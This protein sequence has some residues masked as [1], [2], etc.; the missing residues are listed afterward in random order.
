[1]IIA[2]E[3]QGNTKNGQEL[4]LFLSS[5]ITPMV[6]SLLKHGIDTG[7]DL[8]LDPNFYFSNQDVDTVQLY[9]VRGTKGDQ[10]L[11][12]YAFEARVQMKGDTHLSMVRYP[13]KL[14]HFNYAGEFYKLSSLSMQPFSCVTI[15]DLTN[16]LRAT[17]VYGY[18]LKFKKE[19]VT[20]SGVFPHSTHG[21]AIYSYDPEI[22]DHR[23]SGKTY[24]GR[25][26]L[27]A[28][29][30]YLKMAGYTSAIY[31]CEECGHKRSFTTPNMGI[32]RGRCDGCKALQSSVEPVIQ[33]FVPIAMAEM[34]LEYKDLPTEQVVSTYLNKC[35]DWANSMQL[36]A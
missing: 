3:I 7:V 24:L 22:K 27:E 21:V 35:V 29:I 4:F 1:M 26:P 9:T 30:S 8:T 19:I 31:V 18:N 16:R 33:T 11:Y 10:G 23:E 20:R 14:L 6:S 17:S 2:L 25:E 36:I 12:N 34:L 15:L 5:K 28:H 32:V 13:V